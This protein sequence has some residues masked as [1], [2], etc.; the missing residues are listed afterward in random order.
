MYD[1]EK[2]VPPPEIY[3]NRR[4]RYAI[5][6]F[7]LMEPGDSFY[8]PENGVP[9]RTIAA[10]INNAQSNWRKRNGPDMAFSVYQMGSGVRCWRIR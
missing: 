4:G 7:S 9:S 6:P 2:G 8:V 1:I 5:Y 10:R 3:G